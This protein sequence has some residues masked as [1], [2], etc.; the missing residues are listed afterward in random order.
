MQDIMLEVKSITKRFPGVTALQ[1]VNFINRKGEIHALVVENG[2]GKSTLIKIIAGVYQPDA[3]EIFFDGKKVVWES[4]HQ[5]R[6]K[7]ISV[8]YQEFN[9][10][11]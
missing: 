8:I 9:L 5:S 10:F 11:P 7:G 4:P 1:D 2:A 3:G 6:G